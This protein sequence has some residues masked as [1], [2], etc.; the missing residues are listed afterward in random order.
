MRPSLKDL[1]DAIKAIEPTA[2]VAAF[3]PDQVTV[4]CRRFSTVQAAAGVLSD[5]GW[6][7]HRHRGDKLRIDI[8]GSRYRPE[9][10]VT[11][12]RE[13]TEET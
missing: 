11:G 4:R 12:Y 2:A 13:P 8:E 1:R 9:W 3:G 5:H 7:P 6:T 10:V